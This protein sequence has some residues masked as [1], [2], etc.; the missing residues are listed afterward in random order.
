MEREAPLHPQTFID[1]LK[2]KDFSTC[3][4]DRSVCHELYYDLIDDTA[5][6][7]KLELTKLQWKPAMNRNLAKLLP[8]YTR[9]VELVF[10]YS[11]IG[12][13]GCKAVCSIVR[14]GEDGMPSLTN[15]RLNYCKICDEGALEIARMMPTAPEKL[16]I[17]GLSGNAISSRAAEKIKLANNDKPG[18]R[19]DIVMDES[20]KSEAERASTSGGQS[21]GLAAIL[22][23]KQTTSDRLS[24]SNKERRKSASERH[25]DSLA[26]SS[27]GVVR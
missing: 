9:C 4:A 20:V 8:M 18:R 25:R 23:N 5:W 10:D 27:G 1:E 6:S 16:E 14:L 15:L 3:P 12:D 19:L 11:R 7:T 22:V 21:P 17:L 13:K 2:G 26:G 24:R